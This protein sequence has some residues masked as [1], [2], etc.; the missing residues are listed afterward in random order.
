[1]NQINHFT[2]NKLIETYRILQETDKVL[3]LNFI[4]Q[5]LIEM[6]ILKDNPLVKSRYWTS[7]TIHGEIFTTLQSFG[8]AAIG[9]KEW[10]PYHKKPSRKYRIEHLRLFKDGNTLLSDDKSLKRFTTY[11]FSHELTKEEI[12]E[13]FMLIS[14]EL[15]KLYKFT[16]EGFPLTI[17]CYGDYTFNVWINSEYKSVHSP[18]LSKYYIDNKLQVGDIVYLEKREDDPTGLHLFT[19]WQFERIDG[20]NTEESYHSPV[21][22]KIPKTEVTKSDDKVNQVQ[23]NIDPIYLLAIIQ[24][25]D[26]VYKYLANYGPSYVVEI[27]AVISKFLGVQT[28]I[29]DKLSYIDFSDQRI[30]RLQD[31]RI[32]L[33][34][35]NFTKQDKKVIISS[36]TNDK[37]IKLYVIILAVV[38]IVAVLILLI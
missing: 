16:G 3:T 26:L 2:D 33:K 28:S 24:K 10:T 8:H 7:V 34:E 15:L 12:K 35:T 38:L 1:M 14:G 19:K 18:E 5:K 13:S 31:G 11:I 37:L 21:T 17:Y 20:H 6:N 22:N 30:Y 9:L 4:F 25:E 23:E 27:T 36:I 32:S 29:L